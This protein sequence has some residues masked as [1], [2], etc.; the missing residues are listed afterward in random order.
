MAQKPGC[1]LSMHGAVVA[2]GTV[3]TEPREVD[4]KEGNL[5]PYSLLFSTSGWEN[6]ITYIVMK[7]NFNLFRTI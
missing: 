3:A 1:G 6:T 4:I 7:R 2:N 5:C